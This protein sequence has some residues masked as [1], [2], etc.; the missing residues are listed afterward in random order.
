MAATMNG[1]TWTGVLQRCAQGWRAKA[2]WQPVKILGGDH[3]EEGRMLTVYEATIYIKD[4]AEGQEIELIGGTKV[5]LPYDADIKYVKEICA[6][7]GGFTQGLQGL[8]FR[9]LA[10]ME[11]NPMMCRTLGEGG[12]RGF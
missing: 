3:H 4:D 6:G 1:D 12:L 5:T 10:F 8:G 2:H 9:T 7:I 11:I